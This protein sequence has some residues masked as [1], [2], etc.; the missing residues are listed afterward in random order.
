MNTYAKKSLGQH[1]L[2][3]KAV[4]DAMCDAAEVKS[5]DA[6]LEIGPGTGELTARLL[7]RKVEVLALEIDTS[8]FSQLNKRF[9]NYTSTEF[10]LQE[11][12]IRTYD[13]GNM[14][15]EFKI[16]ANIPYY[17][18]AYLMR[19]L[20][21]ESTHK[22]SIAALLVQKEVAERVTAKPGD[23]SI[24][25][26][27]VQFY[28]EAMVGMVVPAKL[29]IPPP[30]VD[31]QILILK[32]RKQPLLSDVESQP[33]F[34]TVKAGFSNR[35]KTLA[36]SLAGGLRLEKDTVRSLLAS[37]GIN[38]NTRA[39]ELSLEQWQQVHQSISA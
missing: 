2:S 36:N 39:Q 6:V 32:R 27:A 37:V 29:F 20:T 30:K 4:L 16:V 25:S 9:S 12:D 13:F 33:F 5:G 18:T 31:S 26:V 3:D 15:D 11:G 17:L 28:W 19:L 8:L 38:P 1:W 22:P 23:M 21:D 24:L 7:E 34:R 14:P 35:R 10:F